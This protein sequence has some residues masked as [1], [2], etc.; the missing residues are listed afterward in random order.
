LTNRQF[1]KNN[2][3]LASLERRVNRESR[4]GE[5]RK[6]SSEEQEPQHGKVLQASARA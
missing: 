5:R 1:I 3:K 4:R 2:I 6:V